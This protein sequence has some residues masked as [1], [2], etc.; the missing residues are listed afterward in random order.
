MIQMRF[1]G[2][3][4]ALPASNTGF[5]VT[6]TETNQTG[7]AQ[8]RSSGTTTSRTTSYIR[9]VLLNK[10]EA[11]RMEEELLEDVERLNQTVRTFDRKLEF[12]LHRDTDRYFVQVIDV[13]DDEII[14]EIPPEQVLD[15]AGY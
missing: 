1:D 9:E 13:I 6:N 7:R 14:R 11:V 3:S 2:A 15:P 4:G 5:N 12:H 10:E 8:R